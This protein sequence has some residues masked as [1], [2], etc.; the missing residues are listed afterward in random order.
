MRTCPKCRSND[1]RIRWHKHDFSYTESRCCSKYD[2]YHR[3][4]EH[5]HFYCDTCLYDWVED[6]ADDP[7]NISIKSDAQNQVRNGDLK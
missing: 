5:L 2:W 4:D 7:A 1:I 6:T 3:K